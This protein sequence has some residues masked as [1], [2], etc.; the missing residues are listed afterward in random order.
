MASL[1]ISTKATNS[2][3]GGQA[4]T[5]AFNST[6]G[7]LIVLIH[8]MFPIVSGTSP[9]TDNKGNTYT[10]L[11]EQIDGGGARCNIEYVTNATC[12]TGH[13]VSSQ[14]TIDQNAIIVLVFSGSNVSS[15]FDQQNGATGS[16]ATL[17]TGNITPT[18]N[19]EIVVAGLGEYSTSVLAAS[20]FTVQEEVLN[21]PGTNL[22]TGGAYLIQGTAAS[23]GTTWSA[24]GSFGSAAAPI[25][26][27]K[28]T[29]GGGGGG[30]PFLYYAQQRQYRYEHLRRERLI[31]HAG[32]VTILR[33]AA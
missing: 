1:V 30:K 33:R 26:S 25:A 28:T 7:D 29:G 32:R 16:G 24:S 14:N 27:F 9:S 11:T 3:G 23:V 19:N 18:E 2:G 17:A 4:V 6:G 8:S 20:G 5:A 31:E 22:G 13:V 15:S 10:R 21:T 12:G